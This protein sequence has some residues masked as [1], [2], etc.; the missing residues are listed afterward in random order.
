M[1]EKLTII[2]VLITS[3][4]T[5]HSLIMRWKEVCMKYTCLC[6]GYKSL[7]EEPTDTYAICRI[8]FWEDDGLQFRNPDYE[9]GVNGVSLR[10]AQKNF[11]KFGACDE[12]C[13]EFVRKPNRNEKDPHWK[14]FI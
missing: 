12:D 2:R 14:P 11:I 8:C 6:C 3:G 7:D 9:D 1:L 4:L 5:V 13:I 10:Q